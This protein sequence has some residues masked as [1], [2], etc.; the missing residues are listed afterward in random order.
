MN[1]AVEQL[2]LSH[3]FVQR[4]LG[5]F[6][7]QGFAAHDLSRVTLVRT[8]HD[9]LVRVIGFGRLSLFGNGATRLHDRVVSVA[10]RW[11]E[12][13][14]DELRTFADAADR[15]AI[16]LLEQVL[17]E[18]PKLS[19]NDEVRARV[20]AA[21]PKLFARLFAEIRIE[22]DARSRDAENQLTARGAAESAALSEIL[23]TQR[24]SIVAEI[25]RRENEPQ[26]AL[27]FDKREKDQFD[28]ETE[29]MKERLVALEREAK[30][31]PPKIQALYK[32]A[33]RRLEPIG[34]VVLWPET[35]T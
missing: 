23:E 6:L 33:L 26:L 19:A 12:G 16:D 25:E 24:A 20:I 10:A 31:E 18:S 11:I 5:R 8:T 3:P 27:T 34:L 15:K 35:R 13:H 17:L 2:H 4:V 32:V 7:A 21:A 29:H 1:D 30:E 9:A 28:D 22:A 14:E